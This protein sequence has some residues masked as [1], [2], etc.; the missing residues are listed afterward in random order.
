LEDED[1]HFD[2]FFGISDNDNRWLDLSHAR[3]TIGYDPQDDAHEVAG[4]S[5]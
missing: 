4:E 3:E 1:V 5:D 2:V